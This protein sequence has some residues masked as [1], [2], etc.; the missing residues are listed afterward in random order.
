MKNLLK[1]SF[2]FIILCFAVPVFAD[3][4]M[5]TGNKTCTTNCS[6]LMNG[7]TQTPTTLDD[8]IKDET[9]IENFYTWVYQQISQILD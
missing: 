2:L 3:G 4:D 8:R 5:T 9:I 7:T 1:L 6:G